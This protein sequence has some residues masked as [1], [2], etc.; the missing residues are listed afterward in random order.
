MGLRTTIAIN[1]GRS[2]VILVEKKVKVGIQI[3]MY[4]GD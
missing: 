3:E 4:V 1:Y 2:E